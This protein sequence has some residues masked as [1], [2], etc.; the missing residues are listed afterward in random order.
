MKALLMKYNNDSIDKVVNEVECM[1]YSTSF[2]H[3]KKEIIIDLDITSLN[4]IEFKT[5]IFNEFDAVNNFL[6]SLNI[7][8][9][10]DS[11]DKGTQE[12]DAII[13]VAVI[14]NNKVIGEYYIVCSDYSFVNEV[15]TYIDVVKEKR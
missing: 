5:A 13:T 11:Y 3:L 14:E 6:N 2:E 9:M 4:E 1:Y 10:F 7:F 12:I 15:N 8:R